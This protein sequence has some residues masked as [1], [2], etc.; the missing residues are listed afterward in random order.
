MA[1]IVI[2]CATESVVGRYKK[3]ARDSPSGFVLFRPSP[4]HISYCVPFLCVRMLQASAA[5]VGSM[6]TRPS[7]MC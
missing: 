2:S 7:S 5:P 6:A 3:T 1:T 4:W